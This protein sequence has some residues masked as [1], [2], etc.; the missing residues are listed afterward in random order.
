VTLAWSLL[1]LTA[2][3]VPHA[4]RFDRVPSAMAVTFWASALALR[5][6]AAIFL[7]VLVVL[8]LPATD[9]FRAVTQWCWHAVLPPVA[10]HLGLSGHRVGEAAVIVPAAAIAASLVSVLWAM[11]KAA[12]AVRGLVRKRA[13]GPGPA[14]SLMIGGSAVVVA[15][16]GLSRP[17]VVISTGA[18]AAFDDAELAASL[19]HE[20][21]HIV[22]RHRYVL[23]VGEICRA[24]ACFL[25]GSR[26]AA[27]ELAFHLE[28]NADDYAVGRRHDPLALA[29]AICK[30]AL[31]PPV[32]SSALVALG[33]EGVAARLRILVE[34]RP[35]PRLTRRTEWAGRLAAVAM[36]VLTVSLAAE[37][38]SAAAA[39]IHR[40][41]SMSTPSLCPG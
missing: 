11:C 12:R 39:G 8:F 40:I 18:L 22:R 1:L 23:V 26:V 2:V 7:I 32:A 30:A 29:S 24:I 25:P 38:P 33:G 10:A 34:P 9:L 19:D 36:V 20:R 31:R 17:R 35:Q 13:L 3:A 41:A 15:A 14:G 16:A 6:L 21:G 27:R 37:L 5:A 4:V 28:R